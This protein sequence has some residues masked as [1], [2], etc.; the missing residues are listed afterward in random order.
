V[1]G[2]LS[3]AP[4]AEYQPIRMRC[5]RTGPPAGADRATSTDEY[6]PSWS[7]AVRAVSTSTPVVRNQRSAQ[8]VRSTPLTSDIVPIRSASVALRY[9]YR[10]K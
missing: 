7:S 6:R 2:T 10:E 1:T 5:G 3:C 4:V 9:A 8:V